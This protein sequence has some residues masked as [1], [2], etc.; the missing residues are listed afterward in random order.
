MA[1]LVRE[2]LGGIEHRLLAA[3]V[4]QDRA[5]Q[6]VAGRAIEGQRLGILGAGRDDDLPQQLADLGGH[7]GKAGV[8]QCEG[9]VEPAPA[10]HH[11]RVVRKLD[12][13]VGQ[14]QTPVAVFLALG[15]FVDARDARPGLRRM[16]K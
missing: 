15:A 5:P 12:M 10:V 3:R 4:E 7:F 16:L 9:F 8:K 14:E 1:A 11:Q 6:H 13:Q 2:R